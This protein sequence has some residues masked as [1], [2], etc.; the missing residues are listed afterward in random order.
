MDRLIYVAMTGAKSTLEQQASVA[1]NLANV[2]TAGFRAEMNAF[3]AVPVQG[4]GGATRTFVVDSTTGADFAPGPIQHTGRDLDIAVQGKGWI[5]V[6]AADG[7]EA[8]T[9]AGNLRLSANNE[10]VT[11]SGYAVLGDGGPV[12]IPSDTRVTIGGDGTVS[13][14]PT[15]NRVSQNS[16]V[17]R[18]KLVNPP[19]GELE[20]GGDGLFRLKNGGSTPIDD[21][22]RV[23]SGAVESSN[24][25]PVECMVS[26][27]TLSRQFDMQMKLLQNAESNA[28]QASQL[29]GINS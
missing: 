29:L 25:N 12:A 17:G 9:R 23:V 4:E 27:I 21:S 3:R 11:A 6:Q 19:E 1:H 7:T 15:D 16:T 14:V 18:I 20:R 8:Y 26:M 22:V 24:V 2:S 28:R 5:A 13:T 10:L